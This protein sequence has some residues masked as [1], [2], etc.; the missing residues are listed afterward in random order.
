MKNRDE[1]ERELTMTYAK[2]V[3]LSHFS[4]KTFEE[5]SIKA[6][7]LEWVLEK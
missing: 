6:K 2:M 7:V 3:D 1:L 4:K 5:L